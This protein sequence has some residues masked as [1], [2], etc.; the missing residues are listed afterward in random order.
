M[1]CYYYSSL[2]VVFLSCF[3]FEQFCLNDFHL[4]LCFDK[5]LLVYLRFC[6]LF[7]LFCWFCL[8]S[9]KICQNLRHCLHHFLNDGLTLKFEFFS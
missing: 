6:G 4:F 7:K 8:H 9:V 1:I 3:Y 5:E 2:E